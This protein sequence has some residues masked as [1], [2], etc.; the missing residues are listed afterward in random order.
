MKTSLLWSNS[1]T[2]AEVIILSY[3]AS[4]GRAKGVPV[5]IRDPIPI[6]HKFLGKEICWQ[7]T[8]VGGKVNLA[9][10]W[11][12]NVIFDDNASI[13]MEAASWDMEH[14]PGNTKWCDHQWCGGYLQ[15]H[16]DD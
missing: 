14:Y 16:Q 12:A 11:G 7:K 4:T 2:K 10:Q 15:T 5:E 9:W 1:W 3:V 8:G 13:C 6:H